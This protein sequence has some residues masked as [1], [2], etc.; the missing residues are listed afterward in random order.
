MEASNFSGPTGVGAGG[1]N[2][3]REQTTTLCTCV[4]VM[5][6]FSL[7][8]DVYSLPPESEFG[9]IMYFCP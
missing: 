7:I 5:P 8:Q 4:R 6:S 2:S 1:K 9:H 3:D